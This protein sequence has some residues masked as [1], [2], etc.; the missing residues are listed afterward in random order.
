MSINF[1]YECYFQKE[2]GNKQLGLYEGEV[3]LTTEPMKMTWFEAIE[4]AGE[5]SNIR[6]PHYSDIIRAEQYSRENPE[7]RK[8]FPELEEGEFWSSRSERNDS[9]NQY[10]CS[11][12]VEHIYYKSHNLKTDRKW[13]RFIKCG[14]AETP[15]QIRKKN[16]VR[17]GY[18]HEESLHDQAEEE[19]DSYGLGWR[20]RFAIK[21][22]NR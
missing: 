4:I 15:K 10:A 16:I 6:L 21:E 9:K 11:A 5:N 20:E 22:M 8:Q 3:W 14:A 19:L 13:V 2:F 17:D 12:T 7:L 1:A 18:K